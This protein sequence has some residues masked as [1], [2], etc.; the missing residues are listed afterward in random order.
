[1]TLCLKTELFGTNTKYS[2]QFGRKFDLKLVKTY[3]F[4]SVS[5]ELYQAR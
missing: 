3:N 2:L 1:M 5:D 4:K